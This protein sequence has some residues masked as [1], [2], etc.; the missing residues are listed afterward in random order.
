[1]DVD[2]PYPHIDAVVGK[3]ACLRRLPRIR[4]AQV[5]MDYLA[6]GWSAEEMCRQHPALKPAEV[7]AAMAYYFDHQV[8]ID[9]KIAEEQAQLAEDAQAHAK[10]E[11][12][13]RMRAT[14]RV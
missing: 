11:F 13:A 4:V 9:R 10:S 8:E 7:H 6:H 12:W 2:L 3:S 14:G 5:A 1:M